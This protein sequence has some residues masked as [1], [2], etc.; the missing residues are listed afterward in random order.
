V[1]TQWTGE[2]LFKITLAG[3]NAKV[4]DNEELIQKAGTVKQ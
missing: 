1:G 4:K 3:T 2:Q